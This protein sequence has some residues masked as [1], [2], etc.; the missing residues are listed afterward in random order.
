MYSHN[1]IECYK[2]T[3]LNT[4]SNIWTMTSFPNTKTRLFYIDYLSKIDYYRFA[5][6]SFSIRPVLY[7]NYDL[8]IE[9]NSSNDYGSINNPIKIIDKN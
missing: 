8:L 4:N 2:N 6:N 1:E 7:L 9:N 3:W 5:A